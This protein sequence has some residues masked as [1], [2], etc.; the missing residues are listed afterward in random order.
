MLGISPLLLRFSLRHFFFIIIIIC[1]KYQFMY[2]SAAL[3]LQISAPPEAT[4]AAWQDCEYACMR[5][6]YD[7]KPT[8]IDS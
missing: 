2:L 8:K 4:T 7:H 5:E 3:S 6:V 1:P